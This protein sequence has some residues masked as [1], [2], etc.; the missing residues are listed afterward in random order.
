VNKTDFNW[1]IATG[2]NLTES[3]LLQLTLYQEG[4]VE[5][6][7]FSRYFRL[8][9]KADSA[10]VTTS[11][12]PSSLLESSISA[13]TSSSSAVI[14]STPTTVPTT[15]PTPS[16]VTHAN[17]FP[18]SA[19][20]GVGVGIPIAVLLGL[21]VGFFIFRRYKKKETAPPQ[22]PSASVAE[23]YRYG[24]YAPPMNEAP[25]ESLVELDPRHAAGDQPHKAPADDTALRYEM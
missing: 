20:I 8:E 14:N 2:L 1:L 15:V 25:P 3:N 22:T 21:I 24:H 13:T 9:E 19:K 6:D 17:N 5:P 10:S 12:V 23:K 18:T 7:D 11:S 4:E 16:T